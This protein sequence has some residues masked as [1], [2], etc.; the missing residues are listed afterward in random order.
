MLKQLW[1]TGILVAFS[2]FGIKVGL[3]LSAQI[4]NR[5]ISLGKKV[6]FVVGCLFIAK[7]GFNTPPLGA[8]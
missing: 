3:G 7:L 4:C 5:T 2:V 1:I 6:I 8:L